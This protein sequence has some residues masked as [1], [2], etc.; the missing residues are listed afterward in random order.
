MNEAFR[1]RFTSA[2]A[3]LPVDIVDRGVRLDNEI[4]AVPRRMLFEFDGH[5]E[6]T[7]TR[8]RFVQTREG[9]HPYNFPL[10]VSAD[11]GSLL[12]SGVEPDTLPPGV[13]NGRI[14]ID[15][16]EITK[17]G[18]FRIELENGKTTDVV[19]E[20]SKDRRQVSLTKPVAELPRELRRVLT[21]DES[22]VDGMPLVDWLQSATPRASRKVCLL[23]VLA[24]TAALKAPLL[25]SVRS[26]FWA[27]VDRVYAEV[28]PDCATLMQRL[29]DDP[30]KPFYGEGVPKAAI[31]RRLLTCAGVV[32]A[33]YDLL[34]F[35]QEGKHCLQVVV[36]FPRSG[37]GP[38]F[39][40]FDID[41]GNP[42]QDVAGFLVHMGEVASP[43][44]TNHFAL[45]EKLLKSCGEFLC[46]DIVTPHVEARVI[47]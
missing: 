5:G 26:L 39:A 38:H 41:L 28:T 40:E 1:V 23:N 13:Y 12:F 36:G 34:S 14:M 10:T 33:D 32:E 21:A 16:L 9:W 43:A 7:K 31:H 24:K 4:S 6:A 20:A 29:A 25:A 35:R 3:P 47:G 37:H 22:R 15:D 30:A 27:D 18:R 44:R 11:A 42:Y 19:L 2:G 17:H 8:M 45:R 46:Y